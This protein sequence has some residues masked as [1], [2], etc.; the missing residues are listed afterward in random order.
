MGDQPACPRC[1]YDLTGQVATWHAPGADV[2]GA[3]CPSEGTCSECGLRVEWRLVMRPELNARAW[4]VETEQPPRR[5]CSSWRTAWR[6]LRPWSFWRDVRMETPFDARRLR[7]WALCIPL[8]FFGL[9]FGHLS[10]WAMISAIS[11]A[12]RFR[13]FSSFDVST[14]MQLMTMQFGKMFAY[15]A[16]R[17]TSTL[18]PLNGLAWV[19]ALICGIVVPP[20]MFMA[21]PFT[22]AASRVRGRHVV[23]AAVYSLAPIVA[24]AVCGIVIGVLQSVVTYWPLRAAME[25]LQPLES[26]WHITGPRH[27]SLWIGVMLWQMLW[28]ACAFKIGFRMNDWRQA[29][30]AVIV[31]TYLVQI[32]FMY[33]NLSFSIVPRW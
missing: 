27:Q 15:L 5:R 18:S 14:W 16:D 28:W 29:L 20:L 10:L 12:F 22:R 2:E 25:R 26:G 33:V 3:C 17:L 19:T 8:S 24:I 1:D 4:F 30:A 7:W 31:P 6:A 11:E 9:L 32:C 13:Y 23:R 21:L